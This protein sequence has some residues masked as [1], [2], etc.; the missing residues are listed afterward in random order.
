MTRIARF[1]LGTGYPMPDQARRQSHAEQ[2]FPIR[3]LAV[4]E[5][6]GHNTGV[7]LD[8]AVHAFGVS[9][10]VA[11]VMSIGRYTAYAP[12]AYRLAFRSPVFSPWKQSR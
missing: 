11:K 8:T 12:M 6:H 10:A 4:L 3:V 7:Q 5:R 1:L 9:Q 2:D